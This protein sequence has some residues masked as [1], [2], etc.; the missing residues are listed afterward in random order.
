MSELLPNVIFACLM[1]VLSHMHSEKSTLSG[2][3][4]RQEKL[5]YSFMLIAMVLFCGLRTSYNDTYT[6]RLSYEQVKES[7]KTLAEIDWRLGSN[8]GYNV[9]QVLFAQ[10][11]V[12]TQSYLM[13]YAV[14]TVSIYLWFV[15]KYTCNLWLSI[16]FLFTTGAYGFTL[17]AIKQSVA[18]AFCAVATDRALQKKWISFVF[19]VLLASTFHAYSLMYLVLPFLMFTPW[20]L[21][22]FL[23]L[24]VFAVAG[25]G[26]DR[27]LGSVLSITDMM[28]EEY[29]AATF[30]GE[31]VNIFRV[32]VCNVPL[33]LSYLTRKQIGTV[34]DRSWN[35]FVNLAM[36]NGEI[37]FVGL[38]GTANYFARLANYFLI[39]QVL[40]LPW[41]FTLFDERGRRQL[42]G[43]SMVFY[44]IYYA[45]EATVHGSFDANYSRM[46][47]LDYLKS[48]F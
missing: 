20:S 24:A 37:M 14:I 16:F 17:A 7:G 8:P 27:L 46:P 19:W 34:N 15:R 35:L 41:L 18:I 11:G 38:F 31:G 40:A 32:L 9:V 43:L 4:E 3:Y 47:L 45:Y 42:T 36:L 44:W 25:F 13:F 48:L 1:A 28:G 26:M 33:V 12:S 23:M 22:T 30:T 6:Y 2:R 29:N 21:Q 39:F 5:F 10:L